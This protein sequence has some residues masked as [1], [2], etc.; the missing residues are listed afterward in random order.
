MV[1]SFLIHTILTRG[2]GLRVMSMLAILL[3]ILVLGSS[4]LHSDGCHW[5]SAAF[6]CR[7]L[8]CS[9]LVCHFDWQEQTSADAMK[10]EEC[11]M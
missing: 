4:I 2:D 3:S 10:P 6:S 11:L 7:V 1:S 8:I 5:A 9:S